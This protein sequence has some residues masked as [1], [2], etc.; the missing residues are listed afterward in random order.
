M[1]WPFACLPHIQG[2]WLSFE[3]LS[4][5]LRSAFSWRLKHHACRPL[6][7]VFA[8]L[9]FQWLWTR[10][11]LASLSSSLYLLISEWHPTVPVHSPSQQPWTCLGFKLMQLEGLHHLSSFSWVRGWGSSVLHC[12]LPS[13][14]KPQF[15]KPLQFPRCLGWRRQW[16]LTPV[17]LPGKSQGWGSLVDC[18]LWGHTESDTT[19]AT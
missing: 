3:G 10:P 8:A 6:E 18:C 12:A 7:S 19:E 17:L 11:A 13:N 9:S 14:W 1:K 5:T 2:E 15:H 16:Q 4:S